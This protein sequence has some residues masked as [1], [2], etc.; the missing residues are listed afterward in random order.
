M[1]LQ[2]EYFTRNEQCMKIMGQLDTELP[3]ELCSH[4]VSYRPGP[5]SSASISQPLVNSIGG[6]ER[7]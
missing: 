1:R 4:V 7:L 6:I 2:A 3:E 5:G